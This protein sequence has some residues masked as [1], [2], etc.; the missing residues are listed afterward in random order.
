M[1]GP[2]LILPVTLWKH[3]TATEFKASGPIRCHDFSWRKGAQPYG[4]WNNQI[5]CH[6]SYS[7]HQILANK[8]NVNWQGWEWLNK[9]VRPKY[10]YQAAI[11]ALCLPSLAVSGLPVCDLCPSW[12]GQTAGL[13]H[14]AAALWSCPVAETAV[15]AHE[16]NPHNPGVNRKQS[17]YLRV[18][19]NSIYICT[20]SGYM[21]CQGWQILRV[22]NNVSQIRLIRHDESRSE[23]HETIQY[24]VSRGIW[25]AQ[26]Y[27]LYHKCTICDRL[28]NQW[29]KHRS[30]CKGNK[31]NNSETKRERDQC[32]CCIS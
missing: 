23:A 4:T 18:W 26:V 6:A 31:N 28:C 15:P 9:F 21:K 19:K 30:L 7:G 20:G 1:F 8:A 3:P 13:P 10:I 32:E 25:E 14:S 12:W 11:T 22:H 17:I 2:P 29:W 27:L 5:S 24:G 16:Q